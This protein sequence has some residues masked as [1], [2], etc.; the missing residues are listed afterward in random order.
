M[1]SEVSCA[2]LLLGRNP[3][4][5]GFLLALED[6][7][8]LVAPEG[9][10]WIANLGE[11]GCNAVHIASGDV[12]TAFQRKDLVVVEGGV[13]PHVVGEIGPYLVLPL[14]G[15]FNAGVEHTAVVGK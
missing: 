4:C 9:T 5:K 15:E 3:L 10:N 7:V 2:C 1:V 8:H 12:V 14:E 6:A 11:G 13:H